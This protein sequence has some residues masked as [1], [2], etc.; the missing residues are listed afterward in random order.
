MVSCIAPVFM[1]FN[2]LIP[3]RMWKGDEEGYQQ[4]IQPIHFPALFTG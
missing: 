3:V 1:Q 2:P 4:T